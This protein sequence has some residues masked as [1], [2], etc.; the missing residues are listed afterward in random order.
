M[1]LRAGFHGTV[2]QPSAQIIDGSLKFDAGKSEHLKRT[3][4]STGNRKTWTWSGWIKRSVFGADKFIFSAGSD[5][6]NQHYLRFK[7][8]NT[9]E[10]TE[11]ISDSTQSSLITNAVHRDTGWYHLVYV[12]DS[13]QSTSSDRVSLY[14]N[15][16]KQTSLSTNTYP[17]LNH[18]TYINNNSA[19]YIGSSPLPSAY[20][21]GGV[22][23]VYLIDGQALGPEY[24]GFT[25]PLTNTWRPKK[26]DVS[27]IF[28]QYYSH[29]TTSG[30]DNGV[31]S[32]GTRSSLFDGSDT[33][34]V[35]I[36]QSASTYAVACDN[37]SVVCSSTFSVRTWYGASTPTVR[38]TDINDVSTVFE[39]TSGSSLSW[40]DFSYTGTIKKIEI[41]YLG[42]SGSSTQ[43]AG[44]KVDG[45]Y[46]ID[47][48]LNSFHL[49]FDGNS[50]IGQDKSGN[51]NDWTPKNFGGS[52]SVDKAT[53][54]LPI[55]EGAGGAVS[56]VGVRTDANASNLFLALPLVGTTNDVS[57]Q[58]NSGS[59]TKIATNSSVTASTIQSNFYGGAHHWNSNT[60]SL[61]YAQQG[62]D[63][64]FGTGDFTIEFW[65]YDDNGHNGNNNR[66]VL[67]DNRRG[68]NVQGDP[69]Q[70][71]GYVDSHNEINLYYANGSEINITV[72]TTVGKWWHYAAVRSSGTTKLYID[73]VEV[74]SASDTTN[75]PNN[76]IALGS[77]TDSGY[78]WSGYI[79]D[80]RVYK[81]AKYTSNF[82]PASTSPD[83]LPDTPSG[84]SGGS[85]LTK[86]T[87]GAVSFDGTG[88]YL[89]STG[90][91]TLAASSNW[92]M[93]CTFYCTGD[94]SGT[95]RIMGANESSES[96]EYLQ[97]RIRLG[98]YQF[99][100]DNAN[101][102]TGTAAFNKWT[103]MALTK[104]GT[105][106]RAFVDGKELWSTTD[107]NADDITTLIT[108]WGYGSE[109]FPGFISNARF[110]NGSSVYTSE[111][112]PPAVPL[113]NIT[114][115]THLFCQSNTSAT[116]AAVGTIT[117]N[118]DAAATN[119]NP[120][121]TDIN[122][123][124]GQETGYATLNPLK[125]SDTSSIVLSD[126]NLRVDIT[127]NYYNAVS[128]LGMSSGKFYCE[129]SPVRGYSYF[130]I[131]TGDVVPNT[132][133]GDQTNNTAWVL[134]GNGSIYHNNATTNGTGFPSTSGVAGG[135]TLG[136]LFDADNKTMRYV[137]K[138]VVSKVYNMA[139][140]VDGDL[141]YFFV[142]G[143][144]GSYEIDVNFGQKPF[145]FPP[146]DGFQPLN[147][148]NILPETVIAR[149][150]QYFNTT[151]WSG[152]NVD[153][154]VI[155]CGHQPDFVWIKLRNIIGVNAWTHNLYDSVRGFGPDKS[156]RTD[157]TDAQGQLADDYGYVDSAT[158]NG[159]TVAKTG[160]GSY[161]WSLVNASGGNYVAWSWKAGG[162]KNTFNVD[163]VGYANA[164]DVG[165]NV[166]GQN[167]N[168]YDTS[169]L[170]S[171]MMSGPSNSGVYTSLF[172]G[173][174]GNS[175]GYEQPTDGNT[176]TFTPTGGITANSSIE[177]YVYQSSSTY[178]GSAD[179]TVNGTSIKTGAVQSALGT[180]SAG[181]YVNTGT[182]SLTT[183]TW[184]NPSGSNNDY[185]LMA[186]R[187]D[188]KILVDSNQTP[189]NLP[190]IAP[191]GC[192]VGTKQGF[193]IISYTGTGSAGTLPHGL[194]K[195][196]DLI[197][198][199]GRNFAD[200]WRVYHSHLDNSE[201]E[202]YYMILQSTNGKSA[203]QNASFMNDT[204]PTNTVF[205]LGTD[206][207]INGD[208][209]T[210]IAYLWH[211]V[212]GLQKFGTFTANN[213]TDGPY[214]ELG[215]R[216]S[217]VWVK[218]A[219]SAGDMTYASWLITD[220]ERSPTNVVSNGLFANKNVA[221]GKRGNGSD[222]YTGAW[223]D[224]LSN[225]FKIRYTG[226][227]VNGV[228]GQTYIYCAWAEAPAFNLYG[229]QSNAR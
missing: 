116:A 29:F 9:L 189:P 196:P 21:D 164:S 54:A 107:N 160:T 43:F 6:S 134:H 53:G 203:D 119:F 147:G 158:S 1:A 162:S 191:T 48:K 118:G 42:G 86:I 112:N 38:V 140:T 91:G 192:S 127:G 13:T 205:S 34:Y 123:V 126:G 139:N 217:I 131:A 113:T 85:K 143:D 18:D 90:P 169:A 82:A 73:G 148:T 16:V 60:D 144:A 33:S 157:T 8:N 223:L 68:G 59:T 176:L 10:A 72:G 30:S 2:G 174:D 115:T 207:A 88:D 198:M 154:R 208:T 219:S 156:L 36:S 102:L 28:N 130:G 132:W 181:G 120:F 75:Y 161:D 61:L 56:N 204:A 22:S 77:G 218:A 220:G 71:V 58:I 24:F 101:T 3:P 210:M 35:N 62:N 209:R 225:G 65:F 202:D 211:D 15:G 104:S 111:F 190:S 137:Y 50:P 197:I 179:I 193:S 229:G 14:V 216:P 187:V 106:V 96:S 167:S 184:S 11:K 188:G 76:G 135:Y 94:A 108:G 178:S 175:G 93:E 186:I 74:G 105:T 64:V 222:N 19:H 12:F 37:Q 221:E 31:V 165:M 224:I 32:A 141:F 98:Q 200:D 97:M 121:N 45:N 142:G 124:R 136:L 92:C 55:L 89:S 95:Y 163:D 152:D 182:K 185:R 151:L 194:S 81:T 99:Y 17:S 146:P 201:P 226:T 49:P 212:P 7:S 103:H 180:G 69:P 177:I 51:G 83:I 26:L 23:Q 67:F 47:G 114:N 155:D 145:K 173:T 199:K 228:S 172:D 109:Y 57:N 87:D 41:G 27:S 138:G 4:G 215:F 5:A 70:L 159:F 78:S 129:T 170:W 227:E 153:G 206:S 214:V 84:V 128:T 110:V 79:Q 39:V 66:C 44:F 40:Y 100:T 183:L 122:T 80:F 171:G 20:Y 46:L 213:S 149:P 150:N 25:D 125:V 166:G 63:L 168:A 133:G 195:A 117:A 52:T